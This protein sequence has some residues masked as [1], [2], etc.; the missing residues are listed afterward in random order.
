MPRESAPVTEH[1][2]AARAGQ[3]VGRVPRHI[4]DEAAVAPAAGDTDGPRPLGRAHIR[5]VDLARGVAVLGMFAAHVGPDPD[6]PAGQLWAS[7]MA[8]RQHYLSSSQ[9]C[10]WR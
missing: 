10:L 3:G 5:G 6:Q 2:S 1:A 4:D 8:G 7:S 9:G